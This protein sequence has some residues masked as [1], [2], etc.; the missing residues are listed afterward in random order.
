LLAVLRVTDA[1]KAPTPF[2]DP[3]RQLTPS[4]KPRV[5][6]RCAEI[7]DFVKIATLRKD[8]VTAGVLVN[9]AGFLLGGVL[10]GLLLAMGLGSH[11]PNGSTS[12]LSDLADRLSRPVVL[13]GLLGLLWNTGAFLAY[14]F[15]AI[16]TGAHLPGLLTISFAAL[17]FLPA[18]TVHA[19]LSRADRLRTR[20]DRLTIAAAYALSGV[21]AC[22]HAAAFAARAP[23]PSRIGLT[24]LTMGFTLL[25]APLLAITRRAS[26]G[27]A[28][29]IVALSVFAVSALHLTRHTGAEAWW[30]EALGHHSSVLLAL[31]ILH[32][33]YRFGFADIFLKR[34]VSLVLVAALVL[35]AHLTIT[36]AWPEVL[37]LPQP[38]LA[39]YVLAIGMLTA[40]AHQR[41]RLVSNWL[42]DQVVLRRVDYEHVLEAIEHGLPSA[43]D[44]EALTHRVG[45]RLARAIS[46]TSVD[47]VT[48]EG[49][50]QRH[51]PEVLIGRLAMRAADEARA[52]AETEGEAAGLVTIPTV[53]APRFAWRIGHLAAGQRL[54]SDEVRL[55][56]SAA[57]IVAR[58]IDTLRVAG[59]RARAEVREQQV[60]RLAT[61]AE[62]RALRAQLNPHFLF[63]A[64]TTIGYLIRVAPAQAEATLLRLTSVLRAVLRRS[65]SEFTTL[66]EEIELVQSYLEIERAR[67]E[68]RLRITI[69]VPEPLRN[70]RIP[71]LIIQPL[72]EN[73]IK[74]G[75]APLASGGAVVVEARHESP[76]LLRIEVH[77]TG[78]GAVMAGPRET[79]D[80]GIGLSS[81]A[82]RLR[83]HF[84]DRA[85]LAIDSEPGMGTTVAMVLPRDTA[86]S[87]SSAANVVH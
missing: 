33:D 22:L 16:R 15:P 25:L 6:D 41:I 82:Q 8:A 83:C 54:L 80:G 31:A 17:G 64:L 4:G 26:G 10:Y 14:G 53:D 75:I 34:A 66:G 81:V 11:R 51:R 61:E 72:V 85:I 44:E 70:L 28:L 63:N 23:L 73:A 78:C 57:S 21:A 27:R 67:F 46:A 38:S 37:S 39:A 1:R 13:T 19:V 32:W 77:D 62:L 79:P 45:A 47:T 68:E 56:E 12:A 42:V 55:L 65:R 18:V 86:P 36:H 48:L 49:A 84:G 29:W 58:R 87:A 60:G 40:L 52:A 7:G 5:G 35:S 20:S 2:I 71:S 74:H 59:E 30:T 9:I 3:N 76:N 24:V 69:D 50:E 43:A